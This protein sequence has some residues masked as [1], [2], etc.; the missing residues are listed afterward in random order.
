MISEKSLMVA[1][2]QRCGSKKREFTKNVSYVTHEIHFTGNMALHIS[3]KIGKL[4]E[5][6]ASKY[7]INKGFSITDRNYL[8][9]WGE[10]DIV[11]CR[12]GV[13]QFIEVKSVSRENIQS[14]TREPSHRPEDNIGSHKVE[15]L[16]RVIS[17]YISQHGTVE[18]IFSVITVEIDIKDRK[19][20]VSFIEDIVM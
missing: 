15:R 14:V 6:I 16:K 9:R 2:Y 8:R 7:L 4:G 19:A 17:S 18:W 20:Y 11:A 12:H 5:D 3:N 10:I 13:T 1:I